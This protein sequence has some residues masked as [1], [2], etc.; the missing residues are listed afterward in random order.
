MN[1]LL[2]VD[3][4]ELRK[5]RKE[6]AW[7]QRDLARESG[8]AQDTITRLETGKREAQPRTVRRLAEALGVEPRELMRG[9]DDA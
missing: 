9:R 6:Y 8:V 4:M 3:G 7:S 2:E 1:R 5:L